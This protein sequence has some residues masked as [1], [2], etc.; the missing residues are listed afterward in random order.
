MKYLLL[1][2]LLTMG[3]NLWP[4]FLDWIAAIGSLLSGAASAKGMFA[5]DP[6]APRPNPYRPSRYLPENRPPQM[7]QYDPANRQVDIMSYL[8]RFLP[9]Y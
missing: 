3:F 6:E 8:Q 7:P 2:G 4:M 9:R 1:T 5:D